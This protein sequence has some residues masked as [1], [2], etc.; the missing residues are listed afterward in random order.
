MVGAMLP[1]SR[2]SAEKSCMVGNVRFCYEMIMEVEPIYLDRYVMKQFCEPWFDV[3]DRQSPM[4]KSGINLQTA[5][6]RVNR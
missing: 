2:R 3:E 6:E 5:S 1:S 4:G